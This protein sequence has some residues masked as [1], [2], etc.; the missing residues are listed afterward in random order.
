MCHHLLA[1]V[2]EAFPRLLNGIWIL[3][4][5]IY[6]HWRR[7]VAFWDG[8][9]QSVYTKPAESRRRGLISCSCLAS[10]KKTRG[11]KLARIL[12]VL[13]MPRKLCW[14]QIHTSWMTMIPSQKFQRTQVFTFWTLVSA[15]FLT[16]TTCQYY[17]LTSFRSRLLWHNC[18][19]RE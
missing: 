4:I 17:H 3:A 18:K 10:L 8:I 2:F 5:E 15:G 12:F 7:N 9:F 16:T 19:E 1:F 11:L 13:P 14:A 6:V